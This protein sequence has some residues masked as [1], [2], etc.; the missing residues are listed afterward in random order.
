MKVVLSTFFLVSVFALISCSQSHCE[1][2][3]VIFNNYTDAKQKITGAK[4][5]YKESINTS[6]SSWIRKASYFSCND[7]VGYLLIR[8]DSQDYIHED[9]PLQVWKS[10]KTAGPYGS[11][12][13]YNIKGR[14]Q[15]SINQ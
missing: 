14:Y 11:F 13:N 1:K 10:F 9:V 8:T 7:S 12:Y 5:S 15:L 3:P 6:K 4:F 2:L